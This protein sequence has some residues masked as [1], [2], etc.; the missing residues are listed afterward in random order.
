MKKLILLS[1]LLIVGCEGI[2]VEPE[3][4]AGVAGG[5]AIED[6][7]GVCSG[8]AAIDSCGVC[9]GGTTNLEANYL[10]DCLGVCGG[11]AELDGCGICE[12]N[13]YSCYG[14]TDPNASN[15]DADATTDNN[16]CDYSINYAF[17]LNIGNTWTYDYYYTQRL[18]EDL[19]YEIINYQAEMKWSEL[20]PQIGELI[21]TIFYQV[22]LNIIGQKLLFDTL[23]VYELEF[24][25]VNADTSFY[26]FA[27]IN[28]D[29]SGL[30]LYA[31]KEQGVSGNGVY[32]NYLPR[33][34]NDNYI[35]FDKL[36]TGTILSNS[37]A[38]SECDGYTITKWENPLKVLKYPVQL[39][40]FW[41]NV[42]LGA[43]YQ[44]ICEIDNEIMNTYQTEL[45]A[46]KGYTNI[47]DGCLITTTYASLPNLTSDLDYVFTKEYC[48]D[49]IN[50]TLNTY[51]LGSQIFMDAWG[52]ELDISTSYLKMEVSFQLTDTNVVPNN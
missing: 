43:T 19:N 45:F 47:S 44:Y 41:I 4:C 14:C 46:E 36:F 38:R 21:D 5:D 12:G 17:P 8:A 20:S 24:N 26:Q 16:S 6:C 32:V 1:I 18:Y 34:D 50:S 23:N 51:K 9:T 29:I 22:M 40:E 33:L 3:D 25:F 28:E 30:Y 42:N 27:Y 35:G 48:D 2:L 31:T 39:N 15:F 37:L 52:N 13:G 49:G 10:K 11:D 7:L